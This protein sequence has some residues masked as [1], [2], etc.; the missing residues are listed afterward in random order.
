[1]LDLIPEATH[2]W[3]KIWQQPPRSEIAVY[4]D[5]AIMD[6]STFKALATYSCS[7]PSGV[8]PGKMWKAEKDDGWHLYWYDTLY[9]N[10]KLCSIHTRPIRLLKEAA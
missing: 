3:S 7:V 6:S 1:M 9:G 2:P 4:N 5:I 8:Y 10:P